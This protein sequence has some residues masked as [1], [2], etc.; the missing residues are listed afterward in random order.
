MPKN[1]LYIALLGITLFSNYGCVATLLVGG[2]AGAGTVAYLKGE[3]KSYR[4]SIDWQ[5][6]AGSTQS[7]E[8]FGIYRDKRGKKQPF[9]KTDCAWVRR[10]KD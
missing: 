10:Y 7:H 8:R 3:L 5:C 6:L 4:R 9:G 2:G 1:L